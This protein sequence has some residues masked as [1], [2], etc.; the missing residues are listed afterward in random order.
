MYAA[1]LP[2]SL[3][4]FPCGLLFDGP[5]QPLTERNQ[6]MP[7]TQSEKNLAGL[8]V[9]GGVGIGLGWFLDD[10]DAAHG[11]TPRKGPDQEAGLGPTGMRVTG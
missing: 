7:V 4:C 10:L 1:A 8:S 11:A 5:L 2:G 9:Q 3:L 6:S